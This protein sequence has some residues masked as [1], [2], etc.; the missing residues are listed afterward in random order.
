VKFISRA[1]WGAREPKAVKQL[2]PQGQTQHWEGTSLGVFDHESCYT[3]VRGIQAFHMDARGWFD[4]AYSL[5]PCPHG[6]VFEGRGKGI[7]TAASGEPGNSKSEAVCYLGGV[8]DPLTDLGKQAISDAFAYL[9][10]GRDGNQQSWCHSDWMITQCPGDELREFIRSG[11]VLS[12]GSGAI[13]STTPPTTGVQFPDF[14]LP[15]G[16]WYGTPTNDYRNH[17]GYYNVGDR[18]GIFVIQQHLVYRGYDPGPVDGMYG[19]AT[20]RAVAAY[21]KSGYSMD[22]GFEFGTDPN[23]PDGL[24]G[25]KTWETMQWIA[26]NI[27]P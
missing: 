24:T 11:A 14:M 1:E 23:N 9:R 7:Y 27:Y 17:S 18:N 12:G 6:Y 25:A 22:M 3:K 8:G 20:R 5:V 21:Q 19:W 2:S 10:E 13:P 16:H 4:I 15:T 26:A